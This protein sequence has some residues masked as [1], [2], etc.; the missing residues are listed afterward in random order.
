M[1]YLKFKKLPGPVYPAYLIAGGYS[2]ALD[3]E[4]VQSLK[5]ITREAPTPF[6]KTLV[7]KVG[8]NRYLKEMIEEGIS[9]EG[10]EAVLAKRLQDEIRSL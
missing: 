2:I 9:K 7:Q 8:T 1:T 3:P 4:L 10:D 5:E 6:L